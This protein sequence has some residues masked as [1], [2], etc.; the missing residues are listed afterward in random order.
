[1]SEFILIKDALRLY[2]GDKYTLNDHDIYKK[3]KLKGCCEIIPYNLNDDLQSLYFFGNCDVVDLENNTIDKKYFYDNCMR[4]DKEFRQ[5]IEDVYFEDDE[6]SWYDTYCNSRHYLDNMFDKFVMIHCSNNIDML[7]K[8]CDADRINVYSLID[9]NIFVSKGYKISDISDDFRYNYTGIDKEYEMIIWKSKQ[10]KKKISAIFDN[11]KDLESGAQLELFCNTKNQSLIDYATKNMNLLTEKHDTNMKLIKKDIYC[12]KYIRAN[13]ECAICY[14]N[15]ATR[16]NAFLL[17][18]GH[19]FHFSCLAT[20]QHYSDDDYCGKCPMCRDE[21]VIS[22]LHK[23]ISLV[24]LDDDDKYMDMIDN[25]WINFNLIV[26]K[27]CT[28]ADTKHYI[29]MNKNCEYCTDYVNYGDID[30]CGRS[31]NHLIWQ[32]C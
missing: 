32:D 7:C 10:H 8:T 18:C 22:F 30:E 3:I 16:K 2:Y 28:E 20:N 12:K 6:Y 24:W 4:I 19:S 26:P 11:Y 1:M 5:K 17:K 25:F 31:C 21:Y 23:N 29:G 14:E 9:D 27:L 13:D 15:I